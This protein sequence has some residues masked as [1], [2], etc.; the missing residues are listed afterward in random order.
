MQLTLPSRRDILINTGV[1]FVFGLLDLAYNR[2]LTGILNDPAAT[3]ADADQLITLGRYLIAAGIVWFCRGWVW[4]LAG[5][6]GDFRKALFAVLMVVATFCAEQAVDFGIHQAINFLPASIQLSAF[7]LAFYR[8][9]L[10]TGEIKDDDIPMADGAHG[11]TRLIMAA[12]PVLTMSSR[13]LV[14]VNFT[15]DEFRKAVDASSLS[16]IDQKWPELERGLHDLEEYKQKT[17]DAPRIFAQGYQDYLKW[18]AVAGGFGN[19]MD[20]AASKQFYRE[21]DGM[22]P[23]PNASEA[24][25]AQQLQQSYFED[26]RSLG[27]WYFNRTKY[28]AM[29]R[30]ADKRVLVDLPNHRITL[31]DL[32]RPITKESYT[33]FMKARAV[34]ITDDLV[35][36]ID[37]IKKAHANAVVSSVVMPPI[38]LAGTL[39]SGIMEIAGAVLLLASLALGRFAGY[40][41]K[42]AAPLALAIAVGVIAVMPPA[43]TTGAYF[44][45]GPKLPAVVGKV[46]TAEAYFL[47][48]D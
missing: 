44:E 7:K 6:I 1:L 25:F 28:E 21:S 46:L 5:W 2:L 42:L 34:E 32:P 27:N 45:L 14:G 11:E 31:G 20:N 41:A 9:G 13:Y 38:V 47:G 8:H 24:D 37:S 19:A 17:A 43:F 36:T 33:A 35:P 48:I 15:Y 16:T 29:I 22:L 4:R 12:V 40:G 30:D 23:N 18:S 26:K 39:F 10:L 3:Q